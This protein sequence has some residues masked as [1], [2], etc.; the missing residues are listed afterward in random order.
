MKVPRFLVPSRSL[1]HPSGRR[2]RLSFIA[3]CGLLVVV[4]AAGAGLAPPAARAQETP[5]VI[6]TDALNLRG[7]PGTWSGVMSRMWNGEPVTVIG[8]P[9]ADGWYQV[10][11][12]DLVGWSYGGY[13]WI[14]GAPGW[15]PWEETAGAWQSPVAAPLPA[16]GGPGGTA[17]VATD[18]LNVRAAPGETAG[19]VDVIRGGEPVTIVGGPVG[20]YVPI[21]HWT[22]QG[23]VAS[24]LL[25]AAAPATPERWADINRSTQIVTLYEGSMPVASYW[26][27]MG[28]D[29]S[30]DGFFATANGT[31]Y[32]YE[33]YRDL[34]WTVWG[35]AWVRNWIAFDPARLNGFHS[36][37]MDASGSVITD[38]DGPTGGCIALAPAASA[39]VFDFLPFGA[40]VEVHW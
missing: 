2:Q 33:K 6:A 13:L 17:W 20:G 29:Q 4:V 24:S 28:R 7:E 8:G 37:S 1:H 36:Y 26:G 11:Y 30:D 27:A 18:G 19:V 15:A 23:W 31:Y 40:R 12:G 5:A 32:V 3:L 25:G 34:S 9:T 22:G 21:E 38:G 10:R 14:N 39:H 16:V 35:N